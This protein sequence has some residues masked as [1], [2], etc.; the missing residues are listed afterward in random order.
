[1]SEET[2]A[3]AQATAPEQ[4]FSIQRVYLKDL[5][6]ETPQGPAAF[7]KQWQPKVNQDL[8]TKSAKIEEGLFEVALRLTIT[9]SDGDETIYLVEV[10]Q[11]GLFAIQG[12]ED[13]QMA[14]IINTTCPNMLFPYARETIDNV[15]VKG[16]FPALMI[17]PI[18]F[19]ALF[20]SAMQQAAAKAK[21]AESEGED[22]TTH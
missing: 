10:E 14:Q 22:S 16:S 21:E 5:S 13:Q 8:S 4:K 18:N 20:A 15:L 11:A 1:M 6:F 19:D 2:T 7:Q 12:F 17:P 3:A 9:V